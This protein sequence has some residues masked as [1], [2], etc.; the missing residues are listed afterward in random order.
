MISCVIAKNMGAKKTWA[1]VRNPEYSSLS[2]TMSKP[3]GLT[4]FINPEKDAAIVCQQLIDFPVA[5]SFE[6]FSNDKAA[7]VEIRITDNFPLI[8]KNLVSFRT[9]YPN[10]I[11][12]FV[13]V[14][15]ET[16]I[17]KGDY[18]IKE[19]NHLFVT[20]SFSELR[21][22]YKDNG[23]VENRIKSILII[24]G[25][26]VVEY[27]LTLFK[28]RKIDI[29][30]IEV[31]DKRASKLSELFPNI[32]LI[33]VDGTSV[34][35]LDEQRISSYDAVLAMTGI[36]EENIVITM[37]AESKGVKKRLAKINRTELLRIIDS[38][39]LQS[40]I[41]PKRITADN[42][43]QYIRALGNSQGSN[44]EALYKLCDNQIEVLQFRVKEGSKAT[45]KM[46]K[47]TKFIDNIL[48]AYI[49]RNVKLMFPSGNDRIKANDRVIIISSGE[50]HLN[51]LDEIVL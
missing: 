31:D 36:D 48:I 9:K 45:E 24:G 34:E 18:I 12:C 47:E 30:V 42:M 21:K 38:N 7:I 27:L 11:V 28:D 16:F 2:K 8:N 39:S 4:N 35:I 5:E 40:I 22:L 33:N 20:G 43:V 15:G 13:Q 25:G 49:Y 46:I 17:P 32:E 51:D 6:S 1:R 10:L 14:G 41:T 37:V 44:V 3:L 50:R 26:L 23:Q 29:K 19:N